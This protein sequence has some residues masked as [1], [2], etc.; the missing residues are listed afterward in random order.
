MRR[1]TERDLATIIAWTTAFIAKA[2]PGD[3]LDPETHAAHAI[4]TRSLMLADSLRKRGYMVYGGH[5]ST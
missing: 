2:L 5:E 3:P 1:A 4:A